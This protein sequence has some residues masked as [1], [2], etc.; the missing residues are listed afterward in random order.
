MLAHG[1]RH[2]VKADLVHGGVLVVVGSRCA[3]GCPQAGASFKG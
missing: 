1:F 3:Q 2:G